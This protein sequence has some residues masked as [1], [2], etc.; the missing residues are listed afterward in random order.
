M[1]GRVRVLI[2]H[3][4]HQVQA[5]GLRRV[6]SVIRNKMLTNHNISLSWPPLQIMLSQVSRSLGPP[7]PRRAAKGRMPRVRPRK[8]Q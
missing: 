3:R 6:W 1:L 8:R 7:K 5:Q 2:V 4:S